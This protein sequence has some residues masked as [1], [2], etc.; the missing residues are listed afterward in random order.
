MLDPE[1][2]VTPYYGTRGLRTS[3]SSPSST[4][5][6]VGQSSF[7][8]TG[9]AYKLHGTHQV[10]EMCYQRTKNF[11]KLSFLYLITG[12]AIKL[13][14]NRSGIQ[15]P[16]IRSWRCA[17]RGL[18][19]STSS[20][21]STLSQVGPLSLLATG[22]AYKLHGTHQVIE[23]CYQRT[24][25]FDKLSFLYLITGGAI[26]LSCIRSGIQAPNIRSWRCATRGLRTS[27]SSP[28]STLSQVEQSS[29]LAA[30]QLQGKKPSGL[31]DVLHED[32]EF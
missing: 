7:L 9:Q 3:T 1:N 8:A 28:S 15:A 21:S 23:M 16:N 17:T 18:R 29:F 19:T 24:K 2:G 11:D 31:G 20:P 14:C 30:G 5:S 26:K 10:I 4:L 6:Q 32:R 12:G 25:N 27:T 22:Q 13:S